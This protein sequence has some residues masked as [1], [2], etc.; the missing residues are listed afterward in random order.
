MGIVAV[1]V[2]VVAA[3]VVLT[4]TGGCS[5]SP[6]RAR[7]ALEAMGMVDVQLGGY[8]FFSCGSD[9]VFN[10]AF[11]ARNTRGARVEGAVCCGLWKNCTVRTD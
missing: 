3:P 8:P 7:H 9:D 1:M 11:R 6:Q 10:V 5:P 2:V 4:T